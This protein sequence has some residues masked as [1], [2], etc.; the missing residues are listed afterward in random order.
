MEY[1]SGKGN[2]CF[3]SFEWMCSL[4]EKYVRQ[5]LLYKLAYDDLNVCIAVV[6]DF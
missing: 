6:Y 1:S 3:A 5:Y 4:W 2:F